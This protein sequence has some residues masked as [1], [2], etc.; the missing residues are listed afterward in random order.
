MGKRIARWTGICVLASTAC[1][2][3]HVETVHYIGVFDPAQQ[4]AQEL[5]KVTITGD[6]G[7]LS[8]VKYGSGWVPA[9]QA[10]LLRSRL[11]FDDSGAV[12]QSGT[13]TDELDVR[14]N[15]LFFEIGPLGVSKEPENGRFVIVMSSNP[16]FFFQKMGLLTRYGAESGSADEAVQ[17]VLLQVQTD[18]SAAWEKLQT[19]E[20]EKP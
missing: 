20:S 15:R 3:T 9:A 2:A 5:Y 6:S 14:A 4:V 1:T 16:D 18:K 11:H 8:D 7:A 17:K 13:K 10:D 19:I 12:Q